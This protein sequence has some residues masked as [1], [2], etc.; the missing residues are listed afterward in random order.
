MSVAATAY[1]VIGLFK[2]GGWAYRIFGRRAEPQRVAGSTAQHAVGQVVTTVADTTLVRSR[3]KSV[4]C[5]ITR[6]CKVM[7]AHLR[8]HAIARLISFPRVALAIIQ[9]RDVVFF[10]KP[11]LNGPV[12]IRAP[13]FV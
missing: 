2:L 3:A 13:S 1:G 9:T 8:V 5:A 10:S 11:F 4:F 12:L 6:V 7:A